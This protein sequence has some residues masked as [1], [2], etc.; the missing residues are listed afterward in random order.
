MGLRRIYFAA[1]FASLVLVLGWTI[2]KWTGTPAVTESGPDNDKEVLDPG[3]E[4]FT[5]E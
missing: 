4:L 2:F 5:R 1:I 3:N